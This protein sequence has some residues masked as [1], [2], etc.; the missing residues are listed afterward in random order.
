M[1]PDQRSAHSPTAITPTPAT[2]TIRDYGGNETRA[3]TGV[4]D[5][6]EIP[7]APDLRLDTSAGDPA[8]LAARVLAQLETR[9]YITSAAAA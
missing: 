3:F 1:G 4:S 6:Y 8:V 7:E 9:G 2:L 5:P